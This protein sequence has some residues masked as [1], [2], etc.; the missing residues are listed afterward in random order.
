MA[1]LQQ[2]QTLNQK[3]ERLGSKRIL[4]GKRAL[5][6]KSVWFAHIRILPKKT[7]SRGHE[8]FYVD[9]LRVQSFDFAA[10]LDQERVFEIKPC[11]MFAINPR[12]IADLLAKEYSD[13]VPTIVNRKE[14]ELKCHIVGKHE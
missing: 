8:L 11:L 7:K 5:L 12:N 14:E 13:L 3:L 6:H 9:Q 2:Q 1:L 4:E 10:F